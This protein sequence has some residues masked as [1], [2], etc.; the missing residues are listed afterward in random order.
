MGMWGLVCTVLIVASLI[1]AD[2]Y[3]SSCAKGRLCTELSEIP[4]RRAAMVLGCGKYINGRLNMYYKYRIDA[5]VELW[6]AGKIDAILVSG[7]NS[8]KEYDEPSEMKADLVERGIPAEYI[9]IDYAGFRTLDSIVRAKA[10]F[11]LDEYIV[12][13]QPF[14]C[15]R[16]VYLADKKGQSAIGYCAADVHG[17]FGLK[18]RIREIPARAKAVIDILTSKQPKYL[19]P[20]EPVQYRIYEQQK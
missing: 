3:V 8:R 6:Q 14:H 5:A 2:I 9:T 7:D 1:L 11:G 18:V 15:Q 17:G 4:H 19:G 13:S 20:E 16:A 12:V 10:V